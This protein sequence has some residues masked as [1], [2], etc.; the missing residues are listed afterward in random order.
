MMR[1]LIL[2][3]PGAGKGT[4]SELISQK[5]G[6]PHISTGDILRAEISSGSLLGLRVKSL[7]ESGSL[8]PDDIVADVLLKEISKEKYKKGY[9]LDGFP[10]NLNQV[11]IMEEKGIVVD[12][13]IFIDTSEDMILKRI[14]GRRVCSNCGSVYNIYFNLPRIE[15]ICDKC[16]NSLT[17]RKD[18]TE[19]V[20]K[21]RLDTF[22]RETLPVVD[23]YR[24]KKMLLVVNGDKNFEDIKNEIF[25]LLEV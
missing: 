12:K 16:G 25:S 15:S 21:K 23:Y 13:V 22:K 8:V 19:E 7:V 14:T 17:H 3:A 9:I 18:D 2:G 20:V 11:R 4:Q 5:Y 10:R 1:I 24:N 6:I